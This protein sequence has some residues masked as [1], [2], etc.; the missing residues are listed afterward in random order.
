MDKKIKIV[1]A[2]ISCIGIII[3][4][5]DTLN[6]LKDPQI[7]KLYAQ[8]LKN[9]IEDSLIHFKDEALWV[10]KNNIKIFAEK[11]D[12]E[13][14]G[15]RKN[16]IEHFTKANNI[17]SSLLRGKLI[18]SYFNYGTDTYDSIIHYKIPYNVKLLDDIIP[19][20]HENY[21][22][23]VWY[24][25]KK[26]YHTET[27]FSH[28]TKIKQIKYDYYYSL[29]VYDISDIYSIFKTKEKTTSHLFNDFYQQITEP[30]WK[31]S[32]NFYWRSKN[33]TTKAISHITTDKNG[34]RLLQSIFFANSKAYLLEVCA[35]HDLTKRA[36]FILSNITTSNPKKQE[37]PSK[38]TLIKEFIFLLFLL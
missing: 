24:T 9:D 16:N 36:N 29:S 23:D 32:P 14:F 1:L 26:K 20:R 18:S 19:V 33:D 5:F 34:T 6:M 3:L 10:K 17:L 38:T 22:G 2:I 30:K 25:Y 11:K 31:F 27:W 37:L 21:W 12:N 4:T 13:N 28:R 8:H 35:N 15:L 7:R